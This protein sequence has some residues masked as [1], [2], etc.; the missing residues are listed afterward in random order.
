MILY[1]SQPERR[2]HLQM[3]RSAFILAVQ[4]LPGIL[5]VLLG[6]GFDDLPPFFLNP[7]RSGLAAVVLAGVL[8][9]VL[10]GLDFHPLR[11]GLTQ[12]GNQSRQLGVLLIL[13]LSL[14]WF[15][16]FAD[17]RNILTVRYDY[18]RYLGLLLCCSGVSVRLLALNT[19]GEYFS[20][21]VTLQPNH[22]LVR[23][24]IYA[25]IR[26]PLY[27]SLLL[28]PTGVALVFASSLALPILALAA[29]FVLDRIRKEEKLLA[30]H[31]GLVFEDYRRCTWKLIP[32]VL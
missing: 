25:S 10:L 30:A 11:R 1:N 32:L 31:F 27:L 29:I 23:H 21:Y 19:L 12:V 9:A 3:Y 8:A 20:A 22:R 14:L 16:P 13:S 6:W 4:V 2:H 28:A 7:A 24:G 15:L 17:R 18:W 26:H 5:L